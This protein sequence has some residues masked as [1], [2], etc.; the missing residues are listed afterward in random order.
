[1]SLYGQ[2]QLSD[3]SQA[4]LGD[5]HHHHYS[6]NDVEE[7]RE[8]LRSLLLVDP[9]ES[10]DALKA[11][12]GHRVKGTF[13]WFLQCDDFVLWLKSNSTRT[14]LFWLYGHPGT[15]KSTLSVFLVE[16]L[17]K[18][19]SCRD[20]I[21]VLYFFC[22]NTS[23][24]QNSAVAVLRGLL[25]QLSVRCPA[26]LAKALLPEFRAKGTKLFESFQTL[27]HI[28][29]TATSAIS[30]E[31]LVFIDALDEC[32]ELSQGLILQQLE[33]H[34]SCIRVFITS[35]PYPA[36]REVLEEFTYRDLASFK[37]ISADVKLFVSEKVSRL[38][39][40][41]KYTTRLRQDVTDLLGSRAEG[42]FLWVGLVCAEME[43]LTA[44]AGLELLKSLPSGL[45]L[46]YNK[47]FERAVADTV[48]AGEQTEDITNILKFVAVSEVPM[49]TA[50]LSSACDLYQ[51]ESE[52]E[53]ELFMREKIE[54]CRFMV[55]ID[56]KYVRLLHKSVKDFLFGSMTDHFPSLLRAHAELAHRCLS[57]LMQSFQ[58]VQRSTFTLSWDEFYDYAARNWVHHAR[59]AEDEYNVRT[60]QREFFEQKSQCRDDWL[61]YLLAAGEDIPPH[62]SLF[63]VAARWGIITLLDYAISTIA[64][65]GK[66]L[67]QFQDDV[68]NGYGNPLLTA[69]SCPHAHIFDRLLSLR[70]IDTQGRL[71]LIERTDTLASGATTYKL[72]VTDDVMSA[73]CRNTHVGVHLVQTLISHRDRRIV[74]NDKILEAIVENE[75]CGT[76]I[77]K[78]LSK[79]NSVIISPISTPVKHSAR[80][81]TA[82][83]GISDVAEELQGE[84]VFADKAKVESAVQVED[85]ERV[86]KILDYRHKAARISTDLLLRAIRNRTHHNEVFMALLEH[87]EQ[88][89]RISLEDM[90][91][92]AE[93]LDTRVFA[94]VASTMKEMRPLSTMLEYAA[95]NQRYGDELVTMILNAEPECNITEMTFRS[96]AQNRPLGAKILCHF[97]EHSPEVVVS[98]EVVT[99]AMD[100]DGISTKP[101]ASW[102][103]EEIN[104]APG[105]IETRVGMLLP[106]LDAD[107]PFP[108]EALY[109]LIYRD[110]NDEL[111][112]YGSAL[113][114][115]EL[116]SQKYEIILPGRFVQLLG[117]LRLSDE[118]L[119][120]F[121]EKGLV[122]YNETLLELVI[123]HFGVKA[124]EHVLDHG[125][126]PIDSIIIW[127]MIGLTSDDQKVRLL[128]MHSLDQLPNS[129]EPAYT[130][131]DLYYLRDSRAE[132]SVKDTGLLLYS[133][134]FR[135]D[136]YQYLQ[137]LLDSGADPN[138]QS[139]GTSLIQCALE[140]D[141]F[142]CA[143][144]LLQAGADINSLPARGAITMSRM[145]Y[146]AGPTVTQLTELMIENGASVNL[147]HHEFEPPLVA[148]ICQGLEAVIT[149]LI[150]AD[151]DVNAH[152][153]GYYHCPLDALAR[154]TIHIDEKAH[155]RILRGLLQ[156][157]ANLTPELLKSLVR[158]A[159]Q[160]SNNEEIWILARRR[161]WLD[162][163][164]KVFP[165]FGV[166]HYDYDFD[167]IRLLLRLGVDLKELT[168]WDE[169]L[170]RMA[171]QERYR[172]VVSWFSKLTLDADGQRSKARPNHTMK[173][174]TIF[175]TDQGARADL[176]IQ[177]SD[178]E[179]LIHIA[180]AGGQSGI[181]EWLLGKSTHGSTVVN[182]QDVYGR[183]A[184]HRA[185]QWKHYKLAV[186]L[187]ERGASIEIPDGAGYTPS[188]WIAAAADTYGSILPVT[189]ADPK[190][191]CEIRQLQTVGV[192]I[193]LQRYQQKI[194]GTILPGQLGRLLYRH[195]YYDEAAR[196]FEE[197]IE[198][199][200]DP[201]KHT[202]ITCDICD[203]GPI[204]GIRYICVRCDDC[205]LCE[206]CWVQRNSTIN[207][208]CKLHISDFL[209]IPRTNW[210]DIA[211]RES[212]EQWL[213]RL[214]HMFWMKKR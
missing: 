205:D 3:T 150:R 62:F 155:C 208:C 82:T 11:R 33:Q 51:D 207:S 95:A 65:T 191:V 199:D 12:K 118:T 189:G 96:A 198:H 2:I 166:Q 148:A 45:N 204:V 41:K 81:R 101:R 93:F 69:A 20:D 203:Q 91:L 183:T 163:E 123:R 88:P 173:Q 63:D 188:D 134:V 24:D 143:K 214:M 42:T 49:T 210:M 206:T 128:L 58:N 122:L 13:E 52:T 83:S 37:E 149:L 111:A 21:F 84:A 32:D 30:E 72:P 79:H 44:R 181:L 46:I 153:G 60:D 190:K 97:L 90:E 154:S 38:V 194:Q 137:N 55:V 176:Q 138:Y 187:F 68:E 36:I 197:R 17:E 180:A 107:L 139:E 152:A 75:L 100:I 108:A 213:E 102:L 15:G 195:G 104:P 10:K 25:Y 50:Q 43:R 89:V 140:K 48:E 73:I 110:K 193:E 209:A 182:M 19:Y 167:T 59:Q 99:A 106:H 112:L 164:N 8:C 74:L 121:V 34:N 35:R 127:R 125:N 171:V 147:Q 141:R 119:I 31:I 76:Q 39:A 98:A 14:R 192:H 23:K 114:V 80:K 129:L 16:A 115:I 66:T 131:L 6:S 1:M 26:E 103:S 40:R 185:L 28:F 71:S 56:G 196:A 130:P 5:V 133:T 178:G 105:D 92:I 179:T 117:F 47:L 156:A 172:G 78:L 151:A 145:I 94:E 201:P 27:W 184:V 165:P 211:G 158:R 168:H 126:S 212:T 109:G 135:S 200:S 120:A 136:N 64:V 161:T 54:A 116:L 142:H 85:G 162:L 67:V 86:H 22:D 202:H 186:L 124:L 160:K 146:N 144:A 177:N 4:H 57:H 77:L 157:G 53:R 7:W 159:V 29:A 70:A 174:N 113:D 87:A 9:R 132:L 18:Q 169:A 170:I 175:T 61:S